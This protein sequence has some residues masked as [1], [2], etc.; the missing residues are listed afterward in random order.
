MNKK[1]P[2]NDNSITKYYIY[3]IILDLAWLIV[4]QLIKVF[5]QNKLFILITNYCD[6]KNLFITKYLKVIN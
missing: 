3:K 4:W 5:Y 2:T 1:I 6:T